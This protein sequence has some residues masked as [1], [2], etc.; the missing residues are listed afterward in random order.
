MSIAYYL[1]GRWAQALF[2]KSLMRLQE[3]N[4]K[5]GIA[6]VLFGLGMIS[7]EMT[8]AG[9]AKARQHFATRLDLW[10]ESGENFQ[11]TSGLI[12]MACH[13][14]CTDNPWKAAKLLGS[15]DAY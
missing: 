14:I 6:N 2:E 13:A 3:A 1:L 11:F 15:V 5:A 9:M 8:P 10:K 7:L 4:D 12:G